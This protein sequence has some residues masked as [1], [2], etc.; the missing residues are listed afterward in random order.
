MSLSFSYWFP[1]RYRGWV[2]GWFM[3]A[4]PVAIFLGGP[5]STSVLVGLD[6]LL[7][8]A[9]WRWVFLCEAA[10]AV[11]LGIVV[12]FYLT[13]RP[14]KAHWLEPPEGEGLIAELAAQ[15]TPV[16][17]SPSYTRLQPPL[18]PPVLAPAIIYPG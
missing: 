15:R 10:P 1:A 5:I 8:F 11:I 16:E 7:G 6:G 12:L 14:E 2:V 3:T 9:G 18:N 17:Q 13:D 4:I